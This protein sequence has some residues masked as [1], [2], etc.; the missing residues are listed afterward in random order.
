MSKHILHL[1]ESVILGEELSHES[2][3]DILRACAREF[4]ES[5]RYQLELTTTDGQFFAGLNLE[6]LDK[7][8]IR[9]AEFLDSITMSKPIVGSNDQPFSVAIYIGEAQKKKEISFTLI[10]P[11]EESSKAFQAFLIGQIG[12]Y[13]EQFENHTAFRFNRNFWFDTKLSANMIIETMEQLVELFPKRHPLEINILTR[14]NDLLIFNES[15]LSIVKNVLRKG[16]QLWISFFLNGHGGSYLKLQ[17]SYITNLG[18]FGQLKLTTNDQGLNQNVESLILGSMELD[19][20]A[21]TRLKRALAKHPSIYEVI[22][23]PADIKPDRIISA[24]NKITTPYLEYQQLRVVHYQPPFTEQAGP[25][26][27]G[28]MESN[29]EQFRKRKSGILWCFKI[30]KPEFRFYLLFHFQSSGPSTLF[31]YLSLRSERENMKALESIRKYFAKSQ[32]EEG[33]RVT[34]SLQEAFSFDPQLSYDEMIGF[35]E[36]LSAQYL[37]GEILKTRMTLKNKDSRYFYGLEIPLL[38]EA[39]QQKMLESLHISMKEATG[40]QFSIHL[41]FLEKVDGNNGFYSIALDDQ[42]S[43][44]KA[45][46]FVLQGLKA[47]PA[48]SNRRKRSSEGGTGALIENTFS[49]DQTLSSD[50][51]IDA[52]LDLNKSFLPDKAMSIRLMSRDQEEFYFLDNEINKV[53]DLLFRDEV[54]FIYFQKGKSL[55]DK[56]ALYLQFHEQG[57]ESG[58][59]SILTDRAELSKRLRDQI[60]RSLGDQT[61][62]RGIF[63]LKADAGSFHFPLDLSADKLIV[64]LNTLARKFFVGEQ[65]I[66]NKRFNFNVKD[67]KGKGY[68]NLSATEFRNLFTVNRR[69]FSQ[70]SISVLARSGKFLELLLYFDPSRKGAPG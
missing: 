7:I 12:D 32:S 58:F 57:G 46:S 51:I 38:E 16:D 4:F 33:S 55:K 62:V 34:K 19:A 26:N 41:H 22:E 30:Q 6:E 48:L 24:V 21:E 64:F 5:D 45:K 40:Q 67:D 15:E 66:Q 65:F 20:A 39:M 14:K 13:K 27:I 29:L 31:V 28:P 8:L 17:L 60:L 10:T 69:I 3:V 42:E 18:G 47:E 36:S 23:L 59:Y 52:V 50:A 35:M 11:S 37:E 70:L 43:N 61:A 9:Q 68:A 44:L 25:I 49:F 54:A 1:A 53:E 63:S 56:L 2:I